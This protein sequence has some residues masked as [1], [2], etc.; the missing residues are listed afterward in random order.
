M[1]NTKYPKQAT[2]PKTPLSCYRKKCSNRY[3]EYGHLADSGEN[4]K[5]QLGSRSWFSPKTALCLVLKTFALFLRRLHLFVRRTVE[6]LLG[7]PT[8]VPLVLRCVFVS[9]LVLWFMCNLMSQEKITKNNT[10]LEY[11]QNVHCI[12]AC[13]NKI[14]ESKPLIY[15]SHCIKHFF[16]V[17]LMKLREHRV[18]RC[19]IGCDK[20]G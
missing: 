16:L 15:R 14:Q 9:F 17:W 2:S 12:F 18:T 4:H 20:V 11:N 8:A 3:D 5:I 6:A 1:K 10:S 13:R 7:Q 19:G